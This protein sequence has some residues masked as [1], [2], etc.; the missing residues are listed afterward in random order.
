M[1]QA[2]PFPGTGRDLLVVSGPL[3]PA[4]IQALIRQGGVIPAHPLALTEARQLD[5]PRQ[6]ALTRYYLDAGACGLAV[7]VHT[8]QFAVHEPGRG[9]LKPVLSLAAETA[10]AWTDRPVVMIA[11]ICGDTAQACKEAELACELGYHLGLLALRKDLVAGKTDEKAACEALLAHAKAV[12]ERMPVMGFYL[13]E[14]VG[15]CYLSYDFWRRLFEEVPNV[16]AVKVAPFNRYRT[17]D[18]VRALQDAVRDDVA[19]FT[20]NDDHIIEDLLTPFGSGP[21]YFAGGLLG[22]WAVW[23]S[24]AATLVNEI[25][26]VRARPEMPGALLRKAAQLTD[27]N[28][29]IFDVANGFKGCIPGIYEILRRQGLLAGCWCLDEDET[30]S[31]GQA[32]AIDRICRAYPD[33]QDDA[34]VA[35]HLDRWLAP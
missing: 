21:S 23:T 12:A 13:Q 2:H 34:F 18:V 32:A 29:A 26:A 4:P 24:Q 1:V 28:A 14:A 9:L 30:L 15:G 11:G 31:P 25:K 19:L 27:A 10:A 8:T 20:G 35:A 3:P 16:M 17:L 5:E 22:Q 6:R 33:L 7:A